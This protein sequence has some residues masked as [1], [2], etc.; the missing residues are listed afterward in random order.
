MK[1]TDQ[2][3]PIIPPPELVQEW[4]PAF[5]PAPYG[6]ISAHVPDPQ[7]FVNELYRTMLEARP[8]FPGNTNYIGH[9]LD[10]V[11]EQLE[12]AGATTEF[13]DE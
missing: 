8:Y 10:D 1:M 2:Q 3:H 7:E 11:L 5:H 6:E 9:C 13:D 4:P 12:A